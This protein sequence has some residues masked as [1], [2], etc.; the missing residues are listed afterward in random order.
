M[1]WEFENDSKTIDDD[2]DE[3]SSVMYAFRQ[4]IL[5][6]TK[7]GNVTETHV[8]KIRGQSNG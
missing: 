8:Q 2:I 3:K 4:T 5:I 6:K 1:K 7:E